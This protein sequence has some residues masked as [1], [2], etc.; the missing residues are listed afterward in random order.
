MRGGGGVD[1]EWGEE[2]GSQLCRAFKLKLLPVV[3][4]EAHG[5]F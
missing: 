1:E 4:L 2:V 3:K 5:G